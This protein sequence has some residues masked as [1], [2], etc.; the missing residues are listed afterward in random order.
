MIAEEHET[1]V[2]G[3]NR[4]R[5]VGSGLV[6]AELELKK[7]RDKEVNAKHEY[8]KA[9][10]AASLSP[11]A[12]QVT[13]GGV[14][15]A[16][17]AAWVAYQVDVLEFE[18]RVAEANRLAAQTNYAT[19]NTQAMLAQAILKKKGW[20][21]PSGTVVVS[22]ASRWGNPFRVTPTGGTVFGLPW[23]EAREIWGRQPKRDKYALYVSGGGV[24]GGWS[25][26]R[27][28]VRLFRSLMTVRQRDEPEQLSA[29]L[30]PL[31]GHDLACWCRLDEPC[32]ADVLIEIANRP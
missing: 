22:R 19:W 1:P 7:A 16:E 28:A 24:D 21:K 12:P 8:E 30:A 20:R 17:R 15:A 32:H 11:N 29:W 23:F 10:R 31:R 26:A 25:G 13:R 18:F 14:T 2:T 3:R 4:V 5:V 6:A 9:E 27:E